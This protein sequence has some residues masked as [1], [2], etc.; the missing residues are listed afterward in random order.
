MPHKVPT[1]YYSALQSTTPAPLGTTEHYSSTTGHDIALRQNNYTVLLVY[2]SAPQRKTPSTTLYHKVRLQSYFVLQS[3]APVLIRTTKYEF[4][5]NLRAA[6]LVLFFAIPVLLCTT[7]YFSV[8]LQCL[9]QYYPLP[10]QYY[11]HD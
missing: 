11:S 3:T 10:V 5:A 1:H 7:K 4:R 8:L 2:Y 9:P 6:T